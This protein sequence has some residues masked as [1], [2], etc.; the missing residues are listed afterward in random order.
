MKKFI[1]IF[2]TLLLCFGVFGCGTWD[3]DIVQDRMPI[4]SEDEAETVV[5]EDFNYV[6][7]ENI[8]KAGANAL[9]LKMNVPRMVEPWGEV[10]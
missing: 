8:G 1:C 6:Y 5:V 3:T 2:L 7:G 9:V 4:L 10:V